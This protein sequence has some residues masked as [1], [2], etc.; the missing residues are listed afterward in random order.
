MPNT[1]FQDFGEVM[2]FIEA[3][4]GKQ[5]PKASL[6][7]YYECLKEIPADVLRVAARR[8][9]CEH[10][11]A[12]FP[13]V[14]E[15]MQAASETIRG[16]VSEMTAAEAWEKAWS[17]IGRIDLE[18]PHTLES[19]HSLPK[20]VQESIHAFGLPAMVYG[21][22]P[23]TVVRAQFTKIYEQLAARDRRVSLLPESLKDAIEG[24]PAKL[25]ELKRKLPRIGEMPE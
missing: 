9:V 11:W 21:K 14:A 17:A 12:T 15:L 8:V 25:E 24:M 7:A 4:C 20:I 23:V 16:K 5:L 19:L 22:D 6:K 3:T 18:M 13:S 2:V 1:N 10:V